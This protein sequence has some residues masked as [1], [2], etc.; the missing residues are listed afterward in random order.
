MKRPE[1]F[2]KG[3]AMHNAATALLKACASCLETCSC[4]I[5]FNA[6]DRP[7]G[8]LVNLTPVASA[9]N[10]RFLEIA[11]EMSCA[12]IGARIDRITPARI[13]NTCALPPRSS[14]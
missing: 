7:L 5:L 14:L 6:E 1:T 10:S 9:K 3:F 11:N 12:A 2:L 4:L 8:Y 13:R